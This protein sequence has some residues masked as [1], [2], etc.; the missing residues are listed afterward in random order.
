MRRLRQV[1]RLARLCAVLGGGVLL[2]GLV[3]LAE[4]VA[5]RELQALRQ[6]LSQRF[7]GWLAAAL[8]FR[9]EISGKLPEQPMLWVANHVSWTDIP[10]LGQLAP[11][12]F[13]AKA[14]VRR[15]PLAGWLAQCAGTLFIR[16]GAGDGL[17]LGQRIAERLGGGCA[18][19]VFPEGTSSDGRQVLPFHG[20]LL[21]GAITAGVPLQPV[22]LRYLRD[23]VVD[24]LAAFIGED[25]L[26]AH[27]LRL[28][29]A[30]R[31]VLQVQLLEPIAIAGGQR[32][33]LARQARAAIEAALCDEPVTGRQAA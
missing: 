1:L 20:R 19:L 11:L 13:L 6:R 8:P 33:H 3:F 32:S 10:L 7:M 17:L 18:L 23:G 31:A 26:P 30:D 24:P 22:A 14:E 29:A 15:W 16:R 5:R 25:E 4:C 28:F 12:S 2:A 27:L 9:L 21:A